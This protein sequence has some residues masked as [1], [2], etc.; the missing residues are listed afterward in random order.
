M[1]RFEPRLVLPDDWIMPEAWIAWAVSAGLTEREARAAA[2]KWIAAW[3]LKTDVQGRRI[4]LTLTQFFAQWRG[5][6]G[7]NVERAEAAAR[8]PLDEGHARYLRR[9]REEQAK[10]DALDLE[11]GY[12]LQAREIW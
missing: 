12:D 2:A 5:W 4:A 10:A 11:A 3:M 8:K 7:G 1:V 9:A 6:V